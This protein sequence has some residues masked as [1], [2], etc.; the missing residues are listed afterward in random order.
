[1]PSLSVPSATD[2]YAC[3]SSKPKNCDISSE[4]N[5]VS[6]GNCKKNLKEILREIDWK[7]KDCNLDHFC[8]SA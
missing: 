5:F 7:Y 2:V 1:M 8:G 4:C 6:I 3:W